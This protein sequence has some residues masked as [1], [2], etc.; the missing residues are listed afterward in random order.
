MY[1]NCASILLKRKAST[2]YEEQTI[3]KICILIHKKVKRKD[4]KSHAEHLK[5]KPVI[6]DTEIKITNIKQN[7][8]YMN[9]T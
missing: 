1:V 2:L 6:K 3:F 8:S 4:E 9:R 5:S 7:Q